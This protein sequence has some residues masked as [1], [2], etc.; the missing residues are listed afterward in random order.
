[1]RPVFCL[2]VLLGLGGDLLAAA[3]LPRPAPMPVWRVEDLKAGMK[4]HGLTVRKGTRIETFQAELLGVLRNTS[5]GRDLVLARLS[6]IDLEKT[7]V[8][9]GMSGSPVYI[10]GKLVGAVA[11]AWP[12]GK[13]PIAGI[14]PFAQMQAFADAVEK[15]E[16]VKVGLRTKLRS[17]GK[18]FGSVTIAQ[19]AGA[20]GEGLWM[21]PLRTPLAAT[22]FTPHALRLLGKET[23][24]FG[25]VP[26][27]VE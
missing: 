2:A 13:E 23:A 20:D 12:F 4:G 11:F 27:Q 8:I 7:G 25:M 5:P 24:R 1:M 9:A 26:V 22:G 6:G 19:D 15:R 16:P 14:T 18:T 17:G 21:V 10:D 3:G